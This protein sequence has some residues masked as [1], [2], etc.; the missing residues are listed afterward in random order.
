MTRERYRR[1]NDARA[2]REELDEPVII[3]SRTAPVTPSGSNNT[4]VVWAP[5][6]WTR[7][8]VPLVSYHFSDFRLFSLFLT[9]V[10]AMLC[11]WVDGNSIVVGC[12]VSYC[13]V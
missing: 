5:S 10:P 7:V 12:V 13:D 3:G 9:I 6:W 2:A 11:D 8:A 1:V 4:I